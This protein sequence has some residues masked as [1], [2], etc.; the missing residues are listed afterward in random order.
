MSS[1]LQV[2]SVVVVLLGLFAFI[3]F[4]QEVTV[5][6]TV[7]CS[8]QWEHLETRV[9]YPKKISPAELIKLLSDAKVFVL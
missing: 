9:F 1:V 8:N 5:Q 4:N 3:Y 6:T 2:T 7:K